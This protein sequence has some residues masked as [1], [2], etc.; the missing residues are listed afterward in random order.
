MLPSQNFKIFAISSLKSKLSLGFLNTVLPPHPQASL[1]AFLPA[2][3]WGSAG[4]SPPAMQGT[5]VGEILG[6]QKD[7]PLQYSGLENSMDCISIHGITKSDTTERL[8]L[9]TLLTGDILQPQALV[10]TKIS[11]LN[12]ALKCLYSPTVVS[13]TF[14][15]HLIH[16]SN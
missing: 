16:P 15:Y 4:M 3:P 10:S 14:S 12:Y 9:N 8:S 5:W 11:P 2:L 6:E 1:A 7:N 13:S